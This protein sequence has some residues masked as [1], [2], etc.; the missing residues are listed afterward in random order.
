MCKLVPVLRVIGFVFLVLAVL[1]CAL[2]FI[3][4]FWIRVPADDQLIKALDAPS[5]GR[6]LVTDGDKHDTVPQTPPPSQQ[7]SQEP[8]EKLI[9]TTTI[10]PPVSGGVT[11]E[12]ENSAAQGIINSISSILTNG[13]YVGLWAMCHSNLTCKCFWQNDFKMEK[14]FPGYYNVSLVSA[15]LKSTFICINSKS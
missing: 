11:L 1:A 9:Q 13:T 12:G 15:N 6:E 7:Q 8:E 2:G 4:P 10:Q 3:A 5:A 14:A